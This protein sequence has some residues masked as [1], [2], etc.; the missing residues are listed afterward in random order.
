MK[1][2]TRLALQFLVIAL[3]ILFIFSLCIYYFSLQNQQKEFYNRL[4][5]RAL[6]SAQ[7]LITVKE[8]DSLLLNII[9]ENTVNALYD[10]KI[11]V[12]DQGNRLIYH[13]EKK[14][15]PLIVDEEILNRIR[16]NKEYRDKMGDHQLVG[17]LFERG[18]DRFVVI[19]SAKDE[20]GLTQIGYLKVLLISGLLISILIALAAGWVF[21][22]QMLIPI[23]S[24][25]EQVSRITAKDLTLRVNAGSNRDEISQLAQT[26]NSMLERLE[27]AFEMQRKFVAN[28]SHELRTPLTAITGQI[29]VILKKKRTQEEYEAVLRSVLEDARN[30]GKLTNGLLALAQ[31]NADAAETMIKPVRVDELLWETRNDLTKIHPGYKVNIHFPVIPEEEEKFMV[32]GSEQLLKIAFGNLMDNGCKYSQDNKVD[33]DLSFDKGIRIT[34][35]DKGRGIPKDELQRVFQPFYRGT[36]VEQIPGNGLGL[37]LTQKIVQLYGGRLEVSSE[38]GKGTTVNLSFPSWPSF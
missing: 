30:L 17:L 13:H 26:F 11:S 18:D 3:G 16:S 35:R 20:Q 24:V 9:D 7:L 37:S 6:T 33:I 36:N 28:A 25:I 31:A 10:E 14:G 8:V 34:F 23:S 2:R 32:Q 21:A 12:Y 1:I 22:K 5:N 29:D 27:A 19:A 38:P 4:R 15:E